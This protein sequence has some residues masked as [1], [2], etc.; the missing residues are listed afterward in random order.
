MNSMQETALLLEAEKQFG[1]LTWNQLCALGVN[2]NVVHHRLATGLWSRPQRGVY[3]LR[4]GPTT[5][6]ELELAAL[7]AAGPRA[8]LSHQS[9]GRRLGL[10]GVSADRVQLTVPVPYKVEGLQGVDVCRTRDLTEK[11]IVRKGLFR[12][13]SIGRTMIDLAGVLDRT[14]LKVAVDCSLQWSRKN[15]EGFLRTLEEHGPG[16]AGAAAFR[17]LLA[18]YQLDGPLP[19]SVLESLAMEV[20]LLAGRKPHIQYQLVPGKRRSPRF[21]MAW[22]ELQL[23]FEYDSWRWHASRSAFVRDRARDVRSYLQGWLTLRFTWGQVVNRQQFV[24][25]AAGIYE[26]RKQELAGKCADP[27]PL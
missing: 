15:L 18:T 1:L 9:A 11:H 2:R 6:D 10:A 14:S 21:D 13:T 12:Y 4:R 19:E 26:R 20:G 7:L 3:R 22:P 16:R 27:C 25:D 24:Q 5:V 23:G 8:V 17:D